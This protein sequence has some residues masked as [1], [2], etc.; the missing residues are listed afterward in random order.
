VAGIAVDLG[1]L[2]GM[3]VLLDVGVAVIALQ[4]S[5]H[6]GTELVA[7]DRDAMAGC[8]LHRLVG[9]A[10]QAIRL[11]GQP[12]GHSEQEYRE[13]AESDGS[14]P[15]KCLEQA[16]EPLGWTDNYSNQERNNACGFGHA[17]V[18]SSMVRLQLPL[19]TWLPRSGFLRLF[20]KL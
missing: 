2:I 13:E 7:I 1:D 4:A 16:E 12:V 10:S 11:R 20:E 8:V 15:P 17:A 19:R 14:M 3:R 18:S 9:V 5:V 6:A